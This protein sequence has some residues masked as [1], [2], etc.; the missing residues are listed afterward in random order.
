M[1]FG[2]TQTAQCP[3][4]WKQTCP[5]PTGQAPDPGDALGRPATPEPFLG[6]MLAVEELPLGRVAELGHQ[7]PAA[8]EPVPVCGAEPAGKRAARRT[9]DGEKRTD[10]CPAHS[11]S[12][13][14]PGQASLSPL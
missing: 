9:R 5:R 2:A 6:W 13:L 11:G 4:F 10:V 7:G 3:L 1:L 12:T 8:M 14:S